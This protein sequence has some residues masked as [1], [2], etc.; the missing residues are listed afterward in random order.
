MTTHKPISNY[1]P[2]CCVNCEQR[3]AVEPNLFVGDV[4]C[5][6]CGTSLWF[7]QA[8]GESRFYETASTI[9]LR[10]R[11]V[12]F[13]ASSLQIDEAEVMNSPAVL[14]ELGTDSMGTLELLMELEE[15]LDPR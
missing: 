13:I 14:D 11:A 10:L 5:T 3:V 6:N 7:V 15:E 2:N 9:E 12:T 8:A 4:K 1:N